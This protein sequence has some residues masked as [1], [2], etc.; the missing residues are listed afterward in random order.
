[1]FFP[2]CGNA[3]YNKVTDIFAPQE[4]MGP[5]IGNFF[6]IM[7]QPTPESRT[8]QSNDP[9]VKQST[10]KDLTDFKVEAFPVAFGDPTNKII[11]NVQVSTDENKVTAESIVNLQAI[12]DNENKNRTVTTDCSLLSVF[13][14]RSY[15]AGVPAG[16]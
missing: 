11:K 8:L 16:F 4:M 1:M 13:E 5:R 2:I 3:R 10:V 14:G 12:V 15:K 7:F 9:D 6:Q